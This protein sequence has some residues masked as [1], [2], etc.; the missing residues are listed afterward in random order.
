MAA[1]KQRPKDVHLGLRFWIQIEGVEVAG[2]SECSSLTVETEVQ[3]YAEGGLNTYT[4]KLPV[5]TKYGNITLKRGMDVGQD[6]YRWFVESLDGNPK[7][8]RNISIMIYGP[9]PEGEPV[10]QWD[11]IEAWPVKW[12]GPDMKTDA[13]AVAVETLEFAHNG[14]ISRGG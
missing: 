11:L 13:G 6:L 8:R 1:E 9:K 7:K 4:H 14:V 10:K 5:R 2:F 3:E 12:T